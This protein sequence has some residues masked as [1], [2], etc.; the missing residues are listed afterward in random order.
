MPPTGDLPDPEI[1]PVSLAS[2]ILV[3]GFFTSSTTW[4]AQLHTH[5]CTHS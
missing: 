3:D 4:E 1:E 2:P 5:R